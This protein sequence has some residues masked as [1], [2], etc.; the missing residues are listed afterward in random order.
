MPRLHGYRVCATYRRFGRRMRR[1]EDTL[2]MDVMRTV[3]YI[4]NKVTKRR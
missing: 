2:C 4:L 1:R 3:F